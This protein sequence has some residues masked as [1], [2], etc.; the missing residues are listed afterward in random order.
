MPVK[1]GD[2]IYEDPFEKKQVEKKQRVIKNKLNQLKNLVR[3][4]VARA[5][6]AVAVFTA[7]VASHHTRV[8][9]P[10]RVSLAMPTRSRRT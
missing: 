10:L 4:V 1:G 9:L 6:A 2:D 7:H 5:A 3:P 8:S